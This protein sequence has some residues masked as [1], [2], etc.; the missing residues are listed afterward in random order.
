MPQTELGETLLFNNLHTLMLT[1]NDIRI[2]QQLAPLE[3][4]Q[5]SGQTELLS[6]SRFH[7]SG[8]VSRLITF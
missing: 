6:Q 8:R 7:S 4:M 3:K 1:N 5:E 2:F